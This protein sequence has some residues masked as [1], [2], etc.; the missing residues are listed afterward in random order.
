MDLT[1]DS[2]R[3]DSK[4]LSAALKLIRKDRNMLAAEVA[5]KMNLSLSAYEKFENGRIRLNT[6]Y[7]CRFS[8]VT[9]SDRRAILLSVMLGSPGIALYASRSHLIAA[10][11]V[12]FQ[13]ACEG[14][15]H[16]L[17]GV[18][19]RDALAVFR[20]AFRQL[21]DTSEARKAQAVELLRQDPQV[22]IDARKIVG[23]SGGGPKNPFPD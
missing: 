19:V 3:Q 7:I 17:A 15:S 23:L 10:L 5:A 2:H 9:G 8:K 18:D 22:A 12:C 13:E 16:W 1:I 6:E 4:R 11:L 20:N 21:Q 14:S